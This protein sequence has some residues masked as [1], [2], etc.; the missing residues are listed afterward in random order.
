MVCG[1]VYCGNVPSVTE[2]WW[3]VVQCIVVMYRRSQKYDLYNIIIM[4]GT[5][6]NRYFLRKSFVFYYLSLNEYLS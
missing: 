5:V 6:C 3:C 1:A 2:V 4:N